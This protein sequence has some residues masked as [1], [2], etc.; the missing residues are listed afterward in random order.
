MIFVIIQKKQNLT[1]RQKWL[2]TEKKI[3]VKF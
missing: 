2:K 3:E 1:H